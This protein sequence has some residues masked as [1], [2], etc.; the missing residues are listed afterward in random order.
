MTSRF[1]PGYRQLVLDRADRIKLL[2]SLLFMLVGLGMFLDYVN[3]S[4]DAA[5]R[6]LKRAVVRPM[7][8][9]WAEEFVELWT[10]SDFE[11]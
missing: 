6:G 5:R 2:P 1:D 7:R 8:A 9:V 10:C 4:R 3:C 11:S